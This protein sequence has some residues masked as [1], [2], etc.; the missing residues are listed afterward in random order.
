MQLSVCVVNHSNIRLLKP[1]LESIYAHTE[2]V[3]FE[4]IVVDNN[5]VDDSVAVLR[6]EFP[7]VRLIENKITRGYTPNMNMAI[8]AACGQYVALLND[9]TLL[10]SNALG[11]MVAFLESHREFGAV[12][13]KLLNAN[14]SFQLGPRGPA[15][16]WTLLCCELALDRLFTKS[17]LFAG[18]SMTYW[19]SDA[20]CEMQTASGACLVL[21]REVFERVGLLEESIPL[22]PD[23][24]ELSH[25]IRV[26]GWRLY[27]LPSASVIHYGSV[28]RTRVQVE[29]MVRTYKGVCWILAHHFGWRQANAYRL[30]VIGAASL[31]IVGWALIYLAVPSKR[32]R[33]ASRVRGR[34]GILR[35]SLSP[36]FRQSVLAG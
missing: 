28:S 26:A 5:S 11:R 6:R 30:C 21:R 23:D 2:A 16:L 22:G 20:A 25:R 1:C 24:L 36:S 34:W 18:F 32:G 14:G 9:D 8:R 31:R 35:L 3:S 19:N 10:A 12:G 17:R 4:I 15:T 13:P 27:Y 33:A 29:S 7:D